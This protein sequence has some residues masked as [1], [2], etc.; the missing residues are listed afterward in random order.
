MNATQLKRHPALRIEAASFF[1]ASRASAQGKREK[2]IADSL[3][4][5]GTPHKKRC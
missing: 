4:R 1:D 2:D 5:R 3:T